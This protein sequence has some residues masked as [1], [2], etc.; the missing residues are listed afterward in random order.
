M[1]TLCAVVAAL[2]LATLS[3]AQDAETTRRAAEV[4]LQRLRYNNPSLVVDLG[5]GLWGSALPMDYDGDGRADL[6]MG[7]GG[8]PESGVM[9][10]AGD[11]AQ[12]GSQVHQPGRRISKYVTDLQTSF[13]DGQWFVTAAGKRYPTFIQNGLTKSVPIPFK[14]TFHVEKRFCPWKYY[15][16]DA[17]GVADLLIAAY[18]ARAYGWDDAFDGKGNWTN[19][20]QQA[21]F[22]WVKNSGTI[23]KPVFGEAQQIMAGDKPAEVHGLPAVNFA[24]FDGDG[25]PDL[26]SSDGLDYLTFFKNVGTRTE[27]RFAPGR[28]LMRDGQIIRMDLEMLT[29]AAMDYDNDGKMDVVVGEED[30]RVELLRNTG[31]LQ[32]GL[33]LFE[34]PVFL[35]Q[36]AVELKAGVLTTPFG[37]DLDDDGDMDLICGNSA[38]YIAW[39][40]NLG[41]D[42]PKWA[43]PKYLEADGKV[44]RIQAGTNGSIQGPAEAK[45]GYTA[46]CVADWN[47]DGLPDLL[48][49]SIWGKII[50]YQ[51]TGTRPQPAFTTAQPIEVQWD[52]PAR[53][54]AWNWWD[55]QGDQLATQWRCSVQAIDLTGDGLLDLVALDEDGYLAMF[56]R[57]KD[58]GKV[59]PGKR[60]FHVEPGLP[61]VFDHIHDPMTSDENGDGRNDQAGIDAQGRVGFHYR[62]P[63][64]SEMSVKWVSRAG[65]PRYTD[66]E[67]VT[68]LRLNSGWAGR[69]GRCK[70]V[71]CDWDGD[72]KLD[73]IIN[74][75]NAN[76]LKNTSDDPC[77]FV[78]RDMGQMDGLRLAGH[79]TCPAIVDLDHNGIPDLVLGAE[80]GF[81]YYLTNPIQHAG[82]DRR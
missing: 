49:N 44:I 54:P 3:R 24:D 15:D 25:L 13:T 11:S 34:A 21:T 1:W 45:W 33:P 65:D 78:F 43:A 38:G 26:L 75:P 36:H 10:F 81:F 5:V 37:Y 18:D 60:I 47:R 4:K 17:D 63:G 48:I 2:A 6:L 79:D 73:L 20:Q 52:G 31:S 35:K 80:D 61:N 23:A 32:D 14:P 57:A 56:E 28:P 71:L 62:I 76:F 27:P 9:R 77:R 39:F 50:W 40:E 7:W 69:S 8:R 41:G 30:G 59:L 72:G 66:P 74:S 42:P 29:P 53:K 16:Y 51:N 19:G 68:A 70:F 46:V 55:P 58:N 67:N 22:Y 82:S 12:P 64:T